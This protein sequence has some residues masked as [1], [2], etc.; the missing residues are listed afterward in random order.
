MNEEFDTVRDYCDEYTD[1]GECRVRTCLEITLWY[2]DIRSAATAIRQFYDRSLELIRPH[3]QFYCSGRKFRLKALRDDAFEILPHWLDPKT[4]EQSIYLYRLESGGSPTEASDR[5][6]DLYQFTFPGYVRLVLPLEYISE[7]GPAGFIDLARSLAGEMRFLSGW[8]GYGTNVLMN[9]PAADEDNRIYA[10]SRRFRGID[11]GVTFH[12]GRYARQSLRSID[13]L[14]FVGDELLG[15]IGGREALRAGVGDGVTVHDLVHGV[16]VQAGPTPDF[17]DVNRRV[18]L[19]YHHEVGR[20]L[21]ELRIPTNELGQDDT[22][23]G[24]VNTRDWLYRFFPD[25]DLKS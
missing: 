11:V 5:A 14:T 15:K 4:E 20:A 10:I 17:G 18:E 16:M 9:Y 22:I 12:F 6:F 25:T 3:V 1:D 19:P 21:A 24:T 7:V 13:W 8:G 23:A 2:E